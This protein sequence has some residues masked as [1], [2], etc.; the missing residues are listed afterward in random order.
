MNLGAS[1]HMGTIGALWASGGVK[2]DSKKDFSRQKMLN[3]V[4]MWK[5]FCTEIVVVAVVVVFVGIVIGFV[6]V[7][8]VVVVVVVVVVGVV[9]EI[10]LT[11]DI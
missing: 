10:P 7:I 4:K 11:A 2:T 3:N 9:A 5:I 6:V 8:V 1:V